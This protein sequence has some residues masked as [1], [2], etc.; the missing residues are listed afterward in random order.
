LLVGELPA[1][2][3]GQARLLRKGQAIWSETWLSGEDN[4]AHSLANLEHHHFKY[5]NFRRAGDVHVHFFG[6]ATGS[7]TKNIKAE[8][9]D[10][11]EI[12]SPVFGRPLRNPLQPAPEPNRFVAVRT[13]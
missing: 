7:F 3:P 10:V 8:P 12:S 13:L 11:F 5:R 9:G 2:V 1:S 6:A 4:M